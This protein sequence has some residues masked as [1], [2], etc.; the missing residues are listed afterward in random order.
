MKLNLEMSY[1]SKFKIWLKP[2]SLVGARMPAEII[3]LGLAS[4]EL[5]LVGWGWVLLEGSG[6]TEPRRWFWHDQS[7]TFFVPVGSH[8]ILTVANPWGSKRYQLDA[9]SAREEVWVPHDNHFQFRLPDSASTKLPGAPQKSPSRQWLAAGFNAPGRG[10]WRVHLLTGRTVALP[11]HPLPPSDLS[12]L[13][14]PSLKLDHWHATTPME[15]L[16]RRI[17]RAVIAD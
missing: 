7:L 5:S 4:L 17:Q 9:T 11:P 15:D 10:H 2:P 12:L 16:D 6:I 13:A 3:P 8:P 1:F 14:I